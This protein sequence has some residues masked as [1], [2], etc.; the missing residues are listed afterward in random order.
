MSAYSQYHWSKKITVE[1]VIVVLTGLVLAFLGPFGTYAMPSGLRIAYWVIFGVIGY[2]LY[3]PM[4]VITHRLRDIISF[5][6][7]AVELLGCMMAAVPFSFL[8]AF[9][10]AGMQ[11]DWTMIMR[12][13]GLLYVQCTALGFGI[14][15]LMRIIFDRFENDETI[16]Q[17]IREEHIGPSRSALHERLPVG[18]PDRIDALQSEDHYVHVYAHDECGDHKEMILIRL[19]D[20][21]NLLDADGFQTH[22]SWWIARHAA[23][24]YKRDGRKHYFVMDNGQEIPISKTYIASIKQAG[25]I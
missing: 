25:V 18:F 16:M 1:I 19:S 17:D 21:I 7:W 8:V 5:P 3:R 15:L 11:W 4:A 20:A 2:A 13:Y 12:H 9:M 22:R 10:I 14:Y 6:I 23:T 24:H